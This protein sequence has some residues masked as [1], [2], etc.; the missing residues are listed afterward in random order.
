V[1]IA[2]TKPLLCVPIPFR[3]ELF[4]Q[5]SLL[6]LRNEQLHIRCHDN[7]ISFVID[8]TRVDY[9]LLQ[10]EFSVEIG[11]IS[12]P[13]AGIRDVNGN[14]TDPNKGNVKFVKNF[15]PLGTETQV[16]FTISATSNTNGQLNGS[17][18]SACPSSVD[19]KNCTS[20]VMRQYQE[21]LIRN[22]LASMMTLDPTDRISVTNIN[23][24]SNTVTGSVAFTNPFKP[25][26]IPTTLKPTK[27][28]KPSSIRTVKPTRRPTWKPS[29]R[30]T[31]KPV[32]NPSSIPS[33]PITKKPL[34]PTLKPSPLP[35]FVPSAMPTNLQFRSTPGLIYNLGSGYCLDYT[36]NMALAKCTD[37][38]NSTYQQSW[39]TVKVQGFYNLFQI[40][41]KFKYYFKYY[42]Y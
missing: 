27:S 12:I 2:F 6:L 25:T 16:T 40:Q 37:G 20:T 21:S 3:I 7:V 11:R 19:P 34:S 18:C 8:L 28:M 14:P 38:N 35:T 22:E 4:V 33:S 31:T 15:L 32:T 42:M 9:R 30:P 13:T 17:I 36:N 29:R 24:L 1:S 41:K 26:P 23:C 10:G 39:K 5:K